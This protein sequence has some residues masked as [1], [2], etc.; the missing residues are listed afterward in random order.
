METTIINGF[1]ME[2]WC[3]LG[4]KPTLVAQGCCEAA[5]L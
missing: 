5:V 4:G 1:L 3:G 2:G